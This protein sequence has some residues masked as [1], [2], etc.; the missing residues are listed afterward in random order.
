M[1]GRK[2]EAEDGR[3]RRGTAMRRK[4]RE[5]EGNTIMHRR[6]MMIARNVSSR[7]ASC[8]GPP[9]LRPRMLFA[10]G[11]TPGEVVVVEHLRLSLQISNVR[12]QERWR[13]QKLEV[14]LWHTHSL[15]TRNASATAETTRRSG[16]KGSCQYRSCV[17]GRLFRRA[18]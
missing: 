5:R 2:E 14:T 8:A 7:L 10:W 18:T 3:R 15:W 13:L 4:R 1:D 16:L 6:P 9:R 12:G 17:H 11:T